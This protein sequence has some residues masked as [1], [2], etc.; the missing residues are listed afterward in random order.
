MKTLKGLILT[1]ALAM[2]AIS[3]SSDRDHILKVYNWGDY[4]DEELLGEFEQW[5]E[6]QTGEPVEVIYQTF[7]I[8]ETMLSKIE[9]GKEDY[10]VCCPSD[11]IIERM[12]RK[13]LLLPINRD[14]GDTPNYLDAVSPYIQSLFNLLDAGDKS[15]NDY[16]VG[17]MWGTAGIISNEKYVPHEDAMTLD[18]IR[19]PKYAGKIFIKD[20]PRDVYSPILMLLKKD[21]IASGEVTREELMYDSSDESIAA[22]EAYLQQVKPLIAG[23]EADF[24]KEQITQEKSYVNFAWSGDAVWAIREAAEV[25]VK[26]RYD[27]PIEGGNVWFDGWV[28]PKYA[29]NTKAASYFINF[30]CKPENAIRN[31][32]VIGY[33]STIGST[34]IL[35]S[36]IDEE[37]YE[38]IDVTYFFGPDADSVCVDPYIYAP[39]ETI[40]R[41][42]LEHDWGD[43]TEKLIAMWQ[44]VK[45]SSGNSASIIIICAAVAALLVF[46][47]AKKA[48]KNR[49]HSHP[50]KR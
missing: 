12:L 38:P 46:G 1:A 34:E 20:A 24:G 47:L 37:L 7:D 11:Y 27:V 42:T 2:A 3:C 43:D 14:F 5:Y 19:N 36:Q 9:M 17:Y 16:A 33:V 28:I 10:D 21:E 8:N 50:R 32:D 48:G 29:K 31:M 45:G 26:L 30:L 49:R 18:I 35:E 15:A 25:G 4:I 39:M 40:S 13:D 22:V 44:R 6:Q 41:C 23:W